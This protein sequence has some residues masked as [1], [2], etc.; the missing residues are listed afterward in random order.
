MDE[1]KDII[2]IDP[3]YW[4]R[5]G[6]I[7]LN[8]IALTYD[9]TLKEKYKQ[10]ILALPYILPCKKCGYHLKNSINKM[11]NIDNILKNKET[12]I[13]WFLEIRNNI[14]QEQNKELKTIKNC[15]EEIF[16]KQE[17]NEIKYI[18]IILVILIIIYFIYFFYKKKY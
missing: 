8:S 4:G 1:Y 10:F 18:V 14:C 13:N 12:F 3:K 7:F 17:N 2:T 16:D 6:W 9:D 5:C 15:L 11:D